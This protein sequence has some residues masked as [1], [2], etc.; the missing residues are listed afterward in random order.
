MVDEDAVA[1]DRDGYDS[2]TGL[3]QDRCAVRQPW[4][5]ERDGLGASGTQGMG[6]QVKA[7]GE[8]G[9]DQQPLRVRMCGKPAS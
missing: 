2:E 6:E 5:L 1:V 4:V 9:T 7:L 3:V 8:T